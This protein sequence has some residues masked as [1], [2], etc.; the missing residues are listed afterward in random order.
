MIPSF[1]RMAISGQV[2]AIWLVCGPIALGLAWTL[3]H[4]IM[5]LIDRRRDRF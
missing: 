5:T 3:R 4:A 2:D 1:I